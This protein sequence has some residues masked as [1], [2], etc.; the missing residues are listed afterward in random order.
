MVRCA[1]PM[2]AEFTRIRSGPSSAAFATAALI[3]SVSVTST[4][5]NAAADLLGERLALVGLEVGDD[6]RG[7]GGG[8]LAGDGGADARGGAG[9]DG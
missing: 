1:Q 9:D 2:P 4:E 6:D 8:E 7:A 3:C 5:T